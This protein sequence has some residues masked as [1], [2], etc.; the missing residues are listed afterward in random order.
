MKKITAAFDGLKYNKATAAYAQAIA[1][2][3]EALLS[4]VFLEDFLYHSFNFL[5]MVGETAI[6][7][8]KLKQLRDADKQTRANARSIF[9]E[10]C[11][12]QNISYTIHEDTTFALQDLLKESIYTDLL[13]MGMDETLTHYPETRPTSFIR[14]TL[15]G[16]QCP[17]LLV[18]L[19]YT[20]IQKVILLYDGSLSS[21]YAI[22][23]F[24][25]MLRWLG[26]IST[27]V[28]YVSK[29]AEQALPEDTL[30]R[31]F[32]ESHYPNALYL[33]L[34]GDV[35][36]MILNYL[37]KEKPGTLVVLGAYQRSSV[38][39]L[40]RPSLADRLMEVLDLPLFVA[41]QK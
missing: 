34:Q 5:D 12:T 26:S 7:G 16:I 19:S 22:R 40:F 2:A 41:H 28:L 37:Q 1:A 32:I 39:R 25:H 33:T 4:G 3:D 24:H 21:V 29:K 20:P 14:N 36:E 10:S 23:M 15:A 27:C 31:E 18:P 9:K 8:G 35:E 6:P 13:V 38:S 11:I 30:M 17:V